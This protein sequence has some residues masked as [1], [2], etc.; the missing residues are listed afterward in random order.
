MK[1]LLVE[2]PKDIWFIMGEY[3]PPPY[4]IIQLGAY[5]ERELPGVE[6]KVLDCNASQVDWNGLR[7]H[8]KDT[9]PDIV[10][11][12][13]LAT[14]NTYEVART[15]QEVK[16]ADPNIYTVTGGVHFSFLSEE[17]LEEYPE[18][19]AIVRGEGEVTFTELIKRRISNQPLDDVAGLT[20]RDGNVI[21]K[22]PDRPLIEDLNTLPFPGYHLVKDIVHK[23][24][25]AAMSGKE[26]PYALVEGARG[27]LH[28]C[29]FCTQWRHWCGEWRVKSPSR[30]A[31][32]MEY[33]YKEFGSR[34]IWLTDDNFGPGDRAGLLADELLKRDFGDDLMW[35][36]Q[37]R[38]DDV[39]RIKDTLPKLRRAGLHWVMMGVESP[40][41]DQLTRY[42]KGLDSNA[43]YEA[44]RL[45]KEND[46]FT[47]VMLIIGDRKDTHETIANTRR[48]VDDLDPDFVVF[49]TLT[50][51]PGTDVYDSAKEK[52]W[53]EDDNL[54]NYDMA[55]AVMGTET[56][57]KSEVQEELYNCYNHFYSSWSRRIRGILSANELKRSINLY[58]AGRG[59]LVQLKEL[60]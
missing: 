28:K 15:L 19:D 29:T 23:Y 55:H 59:L 36:I 34:F 57:S 32:E 3:L 38:C 6:V 40:L 21:V 27:C 5:V 56:L 9:K 41:P 42:K 50:P 8:V 12:S 37:A 43:S 4:G 14:C 17:S 52:G 2:P 49:T 25:F 30:I 53:I 26:T 51:F 31:D 46:I 45:L 22:N 35:F 47:H 54:F 18:I 39:I 11:S 20:Y 44:V 13:S 10:A 60:I 7:E 48:F 16:K 24:H 1:L 58:M 33:I